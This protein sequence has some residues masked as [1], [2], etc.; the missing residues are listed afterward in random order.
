LSEAQSGNIAYL[1]NNGTIPPPNPLNQ[2]CENV[3]FA[4]S[5]GAACSNP[6][7]TIMY[8]ENGL[9]LYAIDETALMNCA[10]ILKSGIDS[11]CF[12]AKFLPQIYQN[13]QLRLKTPDN[14]INNTDFYISNEL[15][16]NIEILI[17]GT[18]EN[19]KTELY[20]PDTS[21]NYWYKNNFGPLGPMKNNSGKCADPFL[22]AFE[23]CA[24]P[25]TD[26]IPVILNPECGP[27]GVYGWIETSGI[28]RMRN[29]LCKECVNGQL[30]PSLNTTDPCSC[31][32][33]SVNQISG[34]LG[35]SGG[36][37]P[38]AC[39]GLDCVTGVAP[40]GVIITSAT[41]SC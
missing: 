14:V 38:P 16:A 5:S 2:S 19:L 26:I 36:N 27:N 8:D 3:L 6:C 34:N 20:G 10:G 4:F 39:E 18:W 35:C 24:V 11:D 33:Q 28:A 41:G 25:F 31:C 30:V 40:P 9:G 15:V 22:S 13:N 37:C 32:F 17:D 12:K 7:T 23:N 1:Q 21:S 29:E